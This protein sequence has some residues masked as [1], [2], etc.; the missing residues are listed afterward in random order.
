[1]AWGDLAARV[2]ALLD[3]IQSDLLETARKRYDDCIETATTWED[4]MAALDRK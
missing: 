4:F 1:V 3:T 2:P